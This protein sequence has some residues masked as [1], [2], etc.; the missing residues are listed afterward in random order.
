MGWFEVSK[1]GLKQLMEGKDKS[2]ILRELIQNAWDEPGVTTVNVDIAPIMDKR[3]AMV[4]VSDDA[5]EG[6]YDLAHA[7]T[8][9][10]ATRK[11]KD[12]SMR[13]R[14]NLGEKQVLA[15]ARAATIHTTTGTIF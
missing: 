8:M 11:R 13:G 9:F 15:L 14:F 3:A 5:P 7:Y 2:Y 12:P 4:T 10:G 1:S 6:F